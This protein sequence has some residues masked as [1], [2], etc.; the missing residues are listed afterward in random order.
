MLLFRLFID[1]RPAAMQRPAWPS[2][3]LTRIAANAL[4]FVRT[5]CYYSVSYPPE[6]TFFRE[7]PF[8]P[9]QHSRPE[10]GFHPNTLTNSLPCVPP[11]STPLTVAT[12]EPAAVT[13]FPF[14]QFV[15]LRVSILPFPVPS[16]SRGALPLI[17][18]T[19]QTLMLSLSPSTRRVSL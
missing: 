1:I 11:L 19:E 16:T 17:N 2:W 12:T 8:D 3:S 5:L 13:S 4:E 6:I 14:D 15:D 7:M 18:V 10:H 9:D